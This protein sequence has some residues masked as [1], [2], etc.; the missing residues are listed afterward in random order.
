MRTTAR[1]DGNQYILNGTKI[2]ITNGPIA[3]VIVIYAKTAPELG[4]KGISTFIVEKDFPGFCVGKRIV[5]MG[6]K[7]SP[8]GEIIFEDCRVPEENLVREE[9][10]MVRMVLA[11][12][13]RERIIWSADAVGIA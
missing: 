12:L 5:K 4:S 2:F 7:G 8:F 6:H 11:G 3:D 13:L 9:N 10:A 1:K